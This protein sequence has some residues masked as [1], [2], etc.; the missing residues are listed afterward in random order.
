MIEYRWSD[1][2]LDRAQERGL[3]VPSAIL[4][5]AQEVVERD[6]LRPSMASPGTAKCLI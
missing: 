2:K 6:G 3:T 1:G 5:R 4:A